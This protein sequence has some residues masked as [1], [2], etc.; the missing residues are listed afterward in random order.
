ME[1]IQGLAA[2]YGRT[3]CYPTQETLRE[4]V[5]RFTGRTMS[6][7]TLCRHLR[8][9]VEQGY[10]HRIRRHYRDPRRGFVMRSTVYEPALRWRARAG[11]LARAVARAAKSALESGRWCLVTNQAQH[12]IE[13][14][15]SII[16]APA[17]TARAG[18]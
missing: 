7:R 6:R 3:W 13:S 12:L 14:L 17:R 10:L 1:T 5:R 11:R 16:T 9:L 2:R 4:L 18:P 8:A 15:N